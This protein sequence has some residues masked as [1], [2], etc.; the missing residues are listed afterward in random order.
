MLEPFFTKAS[1]MCASSAAKTAWRF[2]IKQSLGVFR[3]N[4]ALPDVDANRLKTGAFY[5]P[6]RP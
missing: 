2:L 5:K 4:A 6:A 3:K 1:F